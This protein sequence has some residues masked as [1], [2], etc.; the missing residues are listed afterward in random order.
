MDDSPVKHRLTTPSL[1][2]LALILAA[3]TFLRIWPSAGFK[4]VGIDEH[5]YATYVEQTLKYGLTGYG[6]VVD[7]YITSQVKERQAVVPATRIGFI[8]PTAIVARITRLD[9]LSAVHAVSATSAI[10]LLFATAAIGMRFGRARQTLVLTALMA[11]APLQVALAQRA[12]GDEYFAF[13]A[14]LSAWFF[15]ECLQNRQSRRWFV[16]FGISFFMLVLT[17]ENAAFVCAALLAVWL[18]FAVAG[19]SRPNYVLVFVMFISGA[20]AVLVLASLL[21]GISEWITFYR[22]YGQKSSGIPYVIQFQDGAWYR[23]LI[24]FTLLSP[25]VVALTFGRVFMIEKKEAPDLFW[26]LFLGFSFVAMSIVP[27]GFSLRFAAY[28]DVP[29][30]WLAASQLVILSGRFSARW[31]NPT[32]ITAL[33][34]ILVVDLEQYCRLFVKAEIYDPVSSHL[35]RASK[36]VK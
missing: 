33:A 1:I 29:L 5:N 32:L 25:L 11:V 35:L 2:L 22:M 8:W 15:F 7:D 26:G 36:L 27:F 3:G 10:L 20:A 28:W 18:W 4:L 6:H 12:L 31:R 19:I 34:L 21:G 14:V 24:D 23:Y 9:S 13:W 16:A 30:R 17:K